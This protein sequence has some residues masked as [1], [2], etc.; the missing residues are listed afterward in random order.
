MHGLGQSE[1]KIYIKKGQ[2]EAYLLGALKEW[3]SW[4]IRG[5]RLIHLGDEEIIPDITEGGFP[6]I[7]DEHVIR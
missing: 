3:R 6:E 4:R 5:F 1:L 7:T 2:V